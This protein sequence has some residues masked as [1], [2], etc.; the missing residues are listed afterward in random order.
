MNSVRFLAAQCRL[1]TRGVYT[2]AVRGFRSVSAANSA[3]TPASSQP[4]SEP[5][6]ARMSPSGPYVDDTE[7]YSSEHLYP[8]EGEYV[9]SSTEEAYGTGRP[10]PINVELNH[11]APIKHKLT[12]G[13]RVADV[14]LRSFTTQNLDFYADFLLRVAFYLRIPVKGVTPLPNKTE[15]WTV[16]RSPFAH[17]KS[18][19]NFQRITHKRLIQLYDANPEVVQVFLATAREYSIG[20]VGV[21]ATLYHKEGLGVIDK[22]DLPETGAESS[23][24]NPLSLENVDLGSADSEVA[25]AVL[26]ILEDPVFKPLMDEAKPTQK[27]E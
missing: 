24:L 2:P 13:H 7:S 23:S 25:R 10:V 22:L 12:H 14:H 27:A 26:D 19:E 3:S 21:K 15:K 18:K 8:K 17:A 6:R 1:A 4:A 5:V 9:Q 20:G 16:I 11:Y